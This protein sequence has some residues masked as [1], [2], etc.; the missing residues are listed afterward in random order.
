MAE[1]F[2]SPIERNSSTWVKIKR[3]LEE[4]LASLRERN[5]KHHDDRKTAQL[6]SSI[7]EVRHLMSLGDA[8]PTPPPE[9]E[10]KD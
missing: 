6:R 4:R 2:L 7:A 5:E 10:F 3:H 9:D 1:A 8:L